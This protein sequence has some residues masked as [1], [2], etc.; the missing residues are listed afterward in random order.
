MDEDMSWDE[1]FKDAG[2]VTL[3]VGSIGIVSARLPLIGLLIQQAILVY[4]VTITMKNKVVDSDEKIKRLV[5][6][7]I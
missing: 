7:G 2:Y 6:L 4:A 1:K 5:H 3:I